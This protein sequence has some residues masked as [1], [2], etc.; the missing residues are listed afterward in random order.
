[1]K[2][3]SSVGWNVM[4]NRVEGLISQLPIKVRFDVDHSQRQEKQT[5]AIQA[6][7]TQQSSQLNSTF[8]AFRNND[9]TGT[10]TCRR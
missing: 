4:F 6:A 3:Y 1:M 10:Y 7:D 2:Y 9:T 8:A 5:S